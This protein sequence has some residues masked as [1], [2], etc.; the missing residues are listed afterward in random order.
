MLGGR[1]VAL[2][3]AK[4]ST[5]TRVSMEVGVSELGGHP[6]VLRGE[7]MQL[8]RGESPR[9]TALVLSRHVAAIG[10]RTASDAEVARARRRR[11]PCR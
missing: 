3:F 11:R 10:I 2:I 9:D 1:S 8:S 4:P 6:V 7:E 5:R